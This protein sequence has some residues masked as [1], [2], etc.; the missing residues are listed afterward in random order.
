MGLLSTGG[1]VGGANVTPKEG[2]IVGEDVVGLLVEGAA[3]GNLV[4]KTDGGDVATG[5]LEGEEEGN[6]V[7]DRVGTDELM[8]MVGASV[9]DGTAAGDK[10]GSTVSVV[11]A[12]SEEA[13]DEERRSTPTPTPTPTPITTATPIAL[14][15]TTFLLMSVA[16]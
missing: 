12:I 6:L 14:S 1:V 5:R 8:V 3:E 10:V 4:G 2:W 7:G 15:T 11:S 9:F 16:N 13:F